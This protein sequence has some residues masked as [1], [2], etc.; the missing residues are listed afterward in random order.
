[1]YLFNFAKKLGVLER[2]KMISLSQ[3]QGL[4]LVAEGLILLLSV[5]QEGRDWVCLHKC[6]LAS[7]WIPEAQSLRF[8]F[9]TQQTMKLHDD[10]RL[11][12]T[13]LACQKIF[14]TSV[15]RAWKE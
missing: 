5:G 13:V 2:L 15:L 8:F 11:W 9:E 14:P 7:S 4:T 12:L 6:H 10:L 3:G 1:M